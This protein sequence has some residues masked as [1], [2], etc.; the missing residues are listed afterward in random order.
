MGRMFLAYACARANP[1]FGG[2]H[3]QRS[4]GLVSLHIGEIDPPYPPYP[5]SMDT[6]GLKTH[7]FV[8]RLTAPRSSLS[9]SNIL[10]ILPATFFATQE[11]GLMGRNTTKSSER[12]MP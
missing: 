7:G 5:P 2:G 8:W 10:P 1:G 11:I 3:T 6:K 12:A 9:V 4:K